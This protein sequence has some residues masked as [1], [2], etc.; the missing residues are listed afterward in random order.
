MQDS[1]LYPVSLVGGRPAGERH[2]GGPGA[3]PARLC[4]QR[5]RLRAQATGGC[6]RTGDGRDFDTLS[7]L[8]QEDQRRI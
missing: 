8:Q 5:A 1:S 7:Q 4:P 3:A 2:P 6:A